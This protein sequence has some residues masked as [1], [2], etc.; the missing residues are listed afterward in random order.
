MEAKTTK[1]SSKGK[2]MTT[3]KVIARLFYYKKKKH[4]KGLL[5]QK[6]KKKAKK[7]SLG[8]TTG[9]MKKIDILKGGEGGF[10]EATLVLEQKKKKYPSS[11]EKK[12]ERNLKEN[13]VLYGHRRNSG[14]DKRGILEAGRRP[15][16]AKQ[17][18][19][20]LYEKTREKELKIEKKRYKKK[21]RGGLEGRVA[22]SIG[23]VVGAGSEKRR[24][25]GGG[26]GKMNE[27]VSLPPR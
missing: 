17:D 24:E 3:L 16:S 9:I 10:F 20:T 13:V 23:G 25:G 12:K 18:R 5:R 4:N 26:C 14:A 27:R 7:N 15:M 8:Q 1:A 2:T 11:V 22:C 19:K 6:K 21:T